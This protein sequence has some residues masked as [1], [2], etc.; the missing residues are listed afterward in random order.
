MWRGKEAEEAGKGD[1]PK[2]QDISAEDKD[3]Q[4]CEG[5]ESSSQTGKAPSLQSM[6]SLSSSRGNPETQVS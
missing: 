3:S 5:E 6:L 1:T 4:Q 2:W